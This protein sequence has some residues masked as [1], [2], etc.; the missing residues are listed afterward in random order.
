M[1]E[2]A[3]VNMNRAAVAQA[4]LSV[5]VL[6]FKIGIALIQEPFFLLLESPPRPRVA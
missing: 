5:N 3:Q 4:E 1:V 6:K 2:L